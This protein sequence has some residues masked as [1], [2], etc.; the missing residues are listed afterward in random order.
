[1][2]RSLVF[3]LS[4]AFLLVSLI[5]IALV[6]F[7]AGRVSTSEFNNFANAQ[8]DSVL[9][10]QLVNYYEINGSWENLD[11]VGIGGVGPNVEEVRP[12]TVVD[13]QGEVV[14][15]GLGQEMGNRVPRGWLNR[16]VRIEVD[17]DEVGQIIFNENRAR[18]MV[19]APRNDFTSRVNRAIFLAALGATA[20]S[21]VIGVLLARSLIKPLQEITRATQAVAQG[22]LKQQVPVR[23]DDEL[24]KLATSFNQMSADLAQSR[25]LRRQMT[26]D[27]AHDLRTPLSL[28]LGHA[29]ALSDGVLPPT[30]ETFDV[31]HDEARRLNRLVEDLRLLSL[32]EAGELSFAVRPVQPQSLLERT[33]VAHTPAAQQKQVELLLDA[34]ADLPDVEVDPD[35]L[36]QVLDNLVSNALRYTP[37]NGRIQLTAQQTP[38]GIQ[39]RVQDSGPGMDAADLAHV[40]DRFYRGDKSRQ[41]HDGGSGLGLAIARSIVESHNGRI[42][43]EST[44]GDGATFIIELPLVSL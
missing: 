28:I 3:K 24:G 42:W 10:D 39:L 21:L 40:F 44:L 35:R 34:P 38:T 2:M 17:G 23:S 11:R 6:A 12:F 16:G 29:E 15:G 31:I 19:Q 1:M 7:F 33:V 37:E 20:V 30:P 5:G 41:R 43:A 8:S 36:A 26:A 18:G 22:D 14:L 4:V 32:A 25:D 9:M 13:A 27:I